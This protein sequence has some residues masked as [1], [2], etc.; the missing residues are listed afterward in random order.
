MK[1]IMHNLWGAILLGLVGNWVVPGE[2]VGCTWYAARLCTLPEAI[3]GAQRCCRNVGGSRTAG[4]NSWVTCGYQQHT[5][6]RAKWM[7]SGRECP[8][9][10][11]CETDPINPDHVRCVPDSQPT[12]RPGGGRKGGGGKP[13][14]GG[15]GGGGGEGGQGGHPPYS[16]PKVGPNAK[17][18]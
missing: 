2:A 10:T 13:P 7:M 15:S 8:Y 3:H 5:R 11:R 6:T 12:G 18:C 1:S 17:A 4:D 14:G 16:N 9:P